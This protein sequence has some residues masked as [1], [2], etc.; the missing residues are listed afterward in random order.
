MVKVSGN[1][2]LETSV[3]SQIQ[4]G[5]ET[6]AEFSERPSR[7]PA[8]YLV[9]DA[10][11]DNP[12]PDTPVSFSWGSTEAWDVSNVDINP[13]VPLAPDGSLTFLNYGDVADA[14]LVVTSDASSTASFNVGSGGTQSFALFRA[15]GETYTIRF[16]WNGQVGKSSGGINFTGTNGNPV[17]WTAENPAAISTS[18]NNFT[19][20]AGQTT[21]WIQLSFVSDAA[22]TVE[23]AGTG[24]G[25]ELDMTDYGGSVTPGSSL[26]NV[27]FQTDGV[28]ESYVAVNATDPTDI[29]EGTPPLDVAWVEQSAVDTTPTAYSST[30][31]NQNVETGG[32]YIQG[33]HNINLPKITTENDG[34]PI[35]IAGIAPW[36]TA[37]MA[38]AAWTPASGDAIEA[39]TLPGG[40]NDIVS[41]IP[42]FG[43]LTW[44]VR[45]G[46]APV[47]EL[48]ASYDTF[49]QMVA[50]SPTTLSAG[51]QVSVTNDP[52]S[53]LN[54]TYTVTGPAGG[55]GT[56]YIK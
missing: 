29:V 20:V 12:G 11:G 35:E 53:N 15:A 51:T 37:A 10:G 24:G 34:Q 43:T 38:A 3:R 7:Q 36:G 4:Y 23:L 5:P 33:D 54:G 30:T 39:I 19:W 27:A 40:S 47:P 44:L 41:L 26:Y 8:Q 9:P 6:V 25:W 22:T 17:T 21:K 1:L 14:T 16:E 50:V 13:Q 2:D 55:P 49:A 32:L 46:G 48:A 56:G 52:T 18:G 45:V 42:V 31:A 28:T